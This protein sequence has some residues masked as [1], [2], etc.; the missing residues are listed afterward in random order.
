[1]GKFKVLGEKMYN[2]ILLM[3]LF[4]ASE[5]GNKKE[6]SGSSSNGT[7]IDSGVESGDNGVNNEFDEDEDGDVES[8]VT[9]P[10]SVVGEDD[11]ASNVDFDENEEDDNDVVNK[12]ETEDIV[13]GEKGDEVEGEEVKDEGDNNDV[14]DKE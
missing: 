10:E 2:L 13:E 9:P 8:F 6:G 5:C 3:I 1:M 11:V 14:V 12:E 7:E 4:I